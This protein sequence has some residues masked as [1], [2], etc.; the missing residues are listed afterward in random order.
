MLHYMIKASKLAPTV[1]MPVGRG[2]DVLPNVYASDVDR[3]VFYK[4]EYADYMVI[5]SRDLAELT[6]QLN[7]LKGTMMKVLVLV[8]GGK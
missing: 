3:L 7:L 1:Y 8:I 4:L 6:V 2:T 5:V